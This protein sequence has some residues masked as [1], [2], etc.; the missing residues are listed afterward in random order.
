MVGRVA[1]EDVFQARLNELLT[2][3]DRRLTNSTVAKELLARGC[4]ASTPYLSQLQ[5]RSY[6][7]NFPVPGRTPESILSQAVGA[8]VSPLMQYAKG[9]PH[10][11]RKFLS[12]F[13]PAGIR[14]LIW[15]AL[16][17]Q[18]SQ[19]TSRPAAPGMGLPVIRAV[20]RNR[21]LARKPYPGLGPIAGSVGH[22]DMPPSTGMTAPVVQLS[23]RARRAIQ[24]AASSGVPA[25]LRGSVAVRVLRSSVSCA[26]VM[27]A[28]RKSEVGM[29]PG[30]MALTRTP[31][32]PS[33][34]AQHRVSWASAAFE[35]A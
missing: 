20:P 23:S 9:R 27:P 14:A 31:S 3:S 13:H 32:G 16:S 25:R 12:T 35:A 21:V 15:T 11:K 30:A 18:T 33:S 28:L 17:L 34:R 7:P 24:I 6:E 4:R 29:G 22:K 10:A 8:L 19:P 5:R 26:S 2:V 1:G